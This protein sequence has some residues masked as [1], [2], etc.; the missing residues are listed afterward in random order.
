[1]RPPIPVN[2]PEGQTRKIALARH[3]AL[4]SFAD[5]SVP[6]GRSSIATFILKCRI[7][8]HVKWQIR[9]LIC[10]IYYYACKGLSLNGRIWVYNMYS[11]ET[12]KTK[13]FIMM[14]NWKTLWSS[15]F[16]QKYFNSVMAKE[17]RLAIVAIIFYTYI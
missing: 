8:H 11:N 10:V 15:W 7:C 14:S 16:I 4:T 3:I 12:A 5:L 1:M 17:S 2:D 9:T 13:T 6:M